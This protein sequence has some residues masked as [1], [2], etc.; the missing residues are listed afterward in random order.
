MFVGLQGSGKTTTCS[1][2]NYILR[3]KSVLG[4]WYKW[5]RLPSKLEFK[6]SIAKKKRKKSSR[7]YIFIIQVFFCLFVLVGHGV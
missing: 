1:K 5:K 2:V 4:A 6:F 3:K 7:S